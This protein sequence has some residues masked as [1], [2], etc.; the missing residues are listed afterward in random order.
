M[1]LPR[2]VAAAPVVEKRN[3]V[4][5]ENVQSVELT[6]MANVP[7]AP[8]KHEESNVALSAKSSPPP[9]VMASAS[10]QSAP[11]L[12]ANTQ[13]LSSGVPTKF[14]P[15]RVPLQPMQDTIAANPAKAI[16]QHPQMVSYADGQLTI[17]AENVTLAAVL[18]MV[19]EKTGAEIEIPPGTG[20]ERIFEHA[21][22][23]R[24]EDVLAMLLNGSPF[25]FVIVG[26]PQG[27]HVPTQVLLSL[28]KA[29]DAP[30]LAQ[31]ARPVVPVV[32]Y[33]P[34]AESPTANTASVYVG[35]IM[36]EAPKEGMSPEDVGNLM[37][38]KTKQLRERIQQQQQQ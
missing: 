29:D 11:I 18:Q 6:S 24:P 9:Q 30:A 10:T 16:G 33:A 15:S 31:P 26:S 1:P 17:N 7:V 38:E 23:G 27:T 35:D 4:P 2:A 22:P 13:P 3:V 19:A 20:Q 21:G 36:P 8:P 14:A 12:R 5:S 34:P 28:H 37:K 32:A 25:D